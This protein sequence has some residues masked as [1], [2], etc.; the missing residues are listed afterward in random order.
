MATESHIFFKSD[1]LIE[2]K[3]R[4]NLFSNVMFST[5]IFKCS[6]T[7]FLP[8]T[9]SYCLKISMNAS[10]YKT[11]LKISINASYYRTRLT[12]SYRCQNP[13]NSSDSETCLT[14]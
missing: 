5:F 10:Y 13:A 1:I 2:S 11:C 12:S 3:A 6:N 4:K 8:Y 9:I 14:Y 7:Y